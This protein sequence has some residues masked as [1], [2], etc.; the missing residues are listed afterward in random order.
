MGKCQSL[1]TKTKR[2]M[3]LELTEQEA[4]VIRGLI[5]REVTA[6]SNRLEQLQTHQAHLRVDEVQMLR[7]KR[8]ELS[9]V[10]NKFNGYAN[11]L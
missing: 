4:K 8:K 3:A 5:Q 10:L 11:Q 6:V 2:N 7:D 9:T 1:S